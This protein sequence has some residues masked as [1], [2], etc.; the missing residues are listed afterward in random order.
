M[1]RHGENIFKRKDGRWEARVIIR[2][3][4][5]HTYRS[6]YG[7]TYTEAKAKKEDFIRRSPFTA[8]IEQKGRVTLKQMAELWLVGVRG[9]VKESTFTRYHRSV[10]AYL[11]PTLGAREITRLDSRTINKFRDDLLSGGG[12][13]GGGLSEKTVT[14][15]LS[16]LALILN[17]AADE[18]YPVMNTSQI[19]C[20][21]GR[22]KGIRTIP[23]G[24]LERLEEIL[25][26]SDDRLSLG[27]LLTI[28][29]GIRVGE[30]CGLR[31]DDLHLDRG[32]LVIARTVERIAE[33]DPTK[34]AKTKIVIDRPKT[35]AS[36]REIPLP[37]LLCEHLISRRGRSGTY[38]L[39]GTDKPSEPHTIY[40]RYKRLLSGNGFADYTLHALRHTFATR[41]VESGFD[42][43]SLSEILGH[44]DVATTLRTYVHPSV[45]QKRK[46]MESLFEQDIRS[47]KYGR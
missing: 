36:A 46:Q 4:G 7:A 20:P 9:T 41:G 44:A 27:I 10:N 35:E 42:T 22:K 18:G 6:L 5:V 19:R 26:E 14:D 38:I 23:E 21:R 13:K 34:K 12:R 24:E 3:D 11:T 25:L 43:K 30:L 31:W 15:I 39:T 32:S 45:E 17:Y 2:R 40:V 37:K 8:N 29:T 16:V 33:L 28:H 47:Q 1:A